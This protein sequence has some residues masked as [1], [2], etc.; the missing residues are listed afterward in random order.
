MAFDYG[1]NQRT[2]YAEVDTY[3]KGRKSNDGYYSITDCSHGRVTI[4]TV[5]C[6]HL[7]KKMQAR[8]AFPNAKMAV[9]ATSYTLPNQTEE[10]LFLFSQICKPELA[11]LLIRKHWSV[12]SIHWELDVNLR[13]DE[14][15]TTKPHCKPGAGCDY[16]RRN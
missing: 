16:P 2:T 15:Q 1:K 12:E 8:C 6:F 13:E 9:L 11:A 4:R 10:R 5:K 3:I 7:S 14:Q